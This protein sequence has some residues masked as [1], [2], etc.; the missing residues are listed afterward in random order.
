MKTYKSLEET[1]NDTNID[2]KFEV[3][4]SS[5]LSEQ[6]LQAIK[7]IVKKQ[8]ISLHRKGQTKLTKPTLDLLKKVNK[9]GVK[10]FHGY[11]LNKAIPALEK[12]LASDKSE[13]TDIEDI[14]ARMFNQNQGGDGET[15]SAI[16]KP[17]KRYPI[18]K[19][20]RV[21]GWATRKENKNNIT[22]LLEIN[23]VQLYNDED[24]ENES[25]KDDTRTKSTSSASSIDSECQISMKDS[26]EVSE[27]EIVSALA[28]DIALY[29][30]YDP[31]LE[32][33]K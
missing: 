20:G 18:M 22:N 3:V 7:D 5:F 11:N 9:M 15:L 21:T 12:E 25:P 2:S 26:P 33:K 17:S 16:K 27:E 10:T 19:G 14:L 13:Q 29:G 24:I 28:Q 31:A 8:L 6:I 1:F 4:E 23:L 30:E 32:S